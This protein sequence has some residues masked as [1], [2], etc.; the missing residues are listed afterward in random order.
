MLPFFSLSPWFFLRCSGLVWPSKSGD[1][2]C[3]TP[4]DGRLHTLS[5]DCWEQS[6]WEFFSCWDDCKMMLNP[7]D[8]ESWIGIS[9]IQ[10]DL[11]F[12]CF[13]MFAPEN[14]GK[15]FNLI[16]LSNGPT[17]WF[18]VVSH[19]EA[20]STEAAFDAKDWI[21]AVVTADTAFKTERG[22]TSLA[23]LRVT[24]RQFIWFQ[25]WPSKKK[26]MER[27]CEFWYS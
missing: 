16:F 2:D 1:S 4:G 13:Y 21:Y 24:R 26:H 18:L 15:W 7:L 25:K 8:S 11:F 20:P 12:I 22:T 3:A 17:T 5:V 10:F 14:C 9:I 19:I 23:W 6:P 27:P